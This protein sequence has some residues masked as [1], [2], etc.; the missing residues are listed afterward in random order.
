MVTDMPERGFVLIMS[1]GPVQSFIAEAR[2][3]QDLWVSSQILQFLSTEALRSVQNSCPD[4]QVVYPA[5]GGSMPN[6]LVAILP[7]DVRCEDIAI[8]AHRAVINAWVQLAESASAVVAKL[9]GDVASRWSEIWRDQCGA[10][11]NDEDAPRSTWVEVFWAAASFTEGG[12]TGAFRKASD[13]LRARKNLREF[14]LVP[15][16][17]GEKC[18][19]NGGLSAL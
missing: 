6:R 15:A 12:Y 2:R 8:A 1:I 17:P 18:T 5:S 14:D 19:L 7:P 16:Q 4:C 13:L 10:W 3:A 9:R 11:I